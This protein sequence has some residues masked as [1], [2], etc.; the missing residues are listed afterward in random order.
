MAVGS[1]GA[2]ARSTNELA[3]AKSDTLA[4]IRD[5]VS[6]VSQEEELARLAQF[7]H[8]HEAAAKFVSVVND[9]LSNLMDI[10]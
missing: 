10:L 6:G 2:S 5:S 8:A 4:S 3:V 1:A 9:M 7:Q